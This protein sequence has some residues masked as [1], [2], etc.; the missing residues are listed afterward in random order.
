MTSSAQEPPKTCKAARRFFSLPSVFRNPKTLVSYVTPSQHGGSREAALSNQARFL[1]ACATLACQSTLWE[2][3]T[4]R[5][6]AEPTWPPSRR[7]A[8]LPW[9]KSRP[10]AGRSP[11]QRGPRNGASLGCNLHRACGEGD[12]IGCNLHQAYEEVPG[13]RDNRAIIVHVCQR[14]L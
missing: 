11:R 14:N 6:R 1:N 8:G 7:R 5:P 12:H 13:A 10:D 9:P 4:G 3:A 2:V